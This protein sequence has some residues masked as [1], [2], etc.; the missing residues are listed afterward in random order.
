MRSGWAGPKASM[1]VR[2]DPCQTRERAGIG[3]VD[4]HAVRHTA[5]C[6]APAGGGHMVRSGVSGMDAMHQ[7]QFLE[8]FR[9][10]EK[11][12]GTTFVLWFFLGWHY[13]YLGKWGVQILYWR[14]L[15][16]LWLWAIADLFRIPGL[17]RDYNKDVAVDVLR[18]MK[19]VSG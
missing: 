1:P 3:R 19:A 17:V 16:G 6:L 9:R 13:A 5:A 12:P 18:T 15:G 11:S 2:V 7:E 14:T 4:A 10:K 8:E